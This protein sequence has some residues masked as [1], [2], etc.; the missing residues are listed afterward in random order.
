MNT[1]A[2]GTQGPSDQG[3][4]CR[5][6]RRMAVAVAGATVVAVAASGTPVLAF[7]SNQHNET[8]VRS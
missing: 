5:P 2:A 4:S 3:T 6:R 1:T 7:I 8:L